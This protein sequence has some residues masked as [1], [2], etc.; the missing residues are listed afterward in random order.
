[1]LVDGQ[2]RL[3]VQDLVQYVG[4]VALGTRIGLPPYRAC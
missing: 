2:L 3:V 1:V 4:C